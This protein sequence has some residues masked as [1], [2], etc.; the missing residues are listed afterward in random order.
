VYFLDFD[1]LIAIEY[2]MKKTMEVKPKIEPFARIKV[3]GIGG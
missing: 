3:L 1:F 2:S